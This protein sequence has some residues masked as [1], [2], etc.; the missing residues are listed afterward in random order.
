MAQG[1]R[2]REAVAQYAAAMTF[3]G[4]LPHNKMIA[5]NLGLCHLRLGEA[6]KAVAW[7]SRAEALAGGAYAKAKRYRAKAERQLALAAPMEIRDGRSVTTSYDDRLVTD[8]LAAEIAQELEGSLD[9]DQVAADL[10]GDTAQ[11][12]KA[13]NV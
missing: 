6:E 7:L 4:D 10:G 12:E 5:F 8:A 2:A 9:M 13:G 3:L 11:V 1:G